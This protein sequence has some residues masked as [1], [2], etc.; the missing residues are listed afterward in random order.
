MSLDIRFTPEAEDTYDSIATQLRQRW[1]E[2]FIIRFE[3]KVTKS[4]NTIA[5]YPELYPVIN[6]ATKV[7]RC[8]L[9]KNCSILYKVYKEAI[10]VICFW[11][12]RQ[13]PLIIF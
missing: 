9:H 5:S 1:G 6:E 11:D 3:A 12:N 10:V 4:L 2:R 13:D 7:R 8:V